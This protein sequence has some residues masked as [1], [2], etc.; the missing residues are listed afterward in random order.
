[1][2]GSQ[3]VPQRWLETL[4]HHQGQGRDCPAIRAGIAAWL[5]HVRGDNGPVDDPKATEMQAAW[6]QNGSAGIVEAMF[7]AAGLVP[8]AWRPTP[9]DH[10]AIA[11]DLG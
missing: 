5:K 8:S 6:S 1:M 3:K 2:D 4:A 10:A 11:A 7:G 9:Q